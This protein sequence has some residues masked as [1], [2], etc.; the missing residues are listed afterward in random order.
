LVSPVSCEGVGVHSGARVSLTMRPAPVDGGIVFAR[1]DES[2]FT[3]RIPAHVDNVTTTR[4]GTT[5]ANAAGVSVATV[6]HVLAALFGMG[7]DNCLVEVDAA[8]VPILDGS[9]EPF[10][11]MIESVGL[12]AQGA[13]RRVIEILKP[14]EARLGDKRAALEPHDGFELD[15]TV[16]FESRAIGRQR[17]VMDCGPES[18]AQ[19]LGAARTFGFLHQVEA[20]RAAGLAQGGSMDNAV[21]ID[22]D[23]ILNDGGLR[24]DDE[25][26]RHKALDAV[27]DLALAG[28]P[29]RGRYVADQSGHELNVALVRALLADA[30]AW[31]WS[32]APVAPAALVAAAGV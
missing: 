23:A 16:D 9:S 29:L 28:A 22:G 17:V 10:V 1:V 4:L 18:F 2:E 15:V 21:V 8:E 6:E 32:F 13:P 14:V 20:L 11:E 27:G 5:I 30:S 19:E 31:R 3:R 12:R 7:V 26:A 25:F 24:Y